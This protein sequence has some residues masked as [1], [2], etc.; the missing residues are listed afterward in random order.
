MNDK[1]VIECLWGSLPPSI[2]LPL[3]LVVWVLEMAGIV[4]R[5]KQSALIIVYA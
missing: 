2:V 3:P 4:R 1:S 5:G